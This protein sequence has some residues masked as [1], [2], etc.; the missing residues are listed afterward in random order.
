[1]N[2]P[3]S[4]D[5]PSDYALDLLRAGLMPADEGAA[6]EQH[7]DGC[8]AC[9]A[10]LAMMRRGFDGEPDV[11]P[12][13]LLAGARRR[14]AEAAEAAT[15]W[16]RRWAVWLPALA[17]AA[18][19]AFF[20]LRPVV[21]PVAPPD[22]VRTKGGL[23][24]YVQLAVDGGSREIVSGERLAPGSRLRFQVD[25]PEAG[26]VAIIGVEADGGRYAVWP[27]DPAASDALDAGDRQLLSGA[28]GLDAA[29]G[30]E[31]LHLVVCAGAEPT[32]ACDIDARGARCPEGCRTTPFELVKGP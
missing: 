13:R 8:P 10:R 23:A 12:R 32:T 31:T 27:L 16:W 21:G 25:L 5:C 30:R 24:L 18:A 15:P 4:P 22:G 28:F 20:A 2:A 1:M 6:L 14:A 19:V 3:G 9:G 11:D 29:P 26:R 17:G 7:V